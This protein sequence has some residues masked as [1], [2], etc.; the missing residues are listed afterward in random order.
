MPDPQPPVD[1]TDPRPIAPI[2]PDFEACC[3][4]GCEPCI[5]DL[6]AI[7]RERYFSALRA[8]DERQRAKPAQPGAPD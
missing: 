8:W 7:E 3:G 5:F 4:N 1:T 6:Y 2:E